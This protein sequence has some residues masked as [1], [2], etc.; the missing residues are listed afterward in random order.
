MIDVCWDSQTYNFGQASTPAFDFVR[1][2]P[3][4]PRRM[5]IVFR[6][7]IFGSGSIYFNAKPPTVP[8]PPGLSLISYFQLATGA[9]ASTPPIHYNHFG[10]I[11][12]Q[13]IFCASIPGDI[14]E[15][16]EM[17]ADFTGV[18]NSNDGLTGCNL[19][20]RG[21]ASIHQVGTPAVQLLQQNPQRTHVIIPTVNPNGASFL[22]SASGVTTNRFLAMPDSSS[23]VLDIS[24]V[25]PIVTN[26]WYWMPTVDGTAGQLAYE[27]FVVG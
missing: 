23:A 18:T 21:W 7:K 1:L 19:G 11:M 9:L 16:A 27:L 24:D 15:Y 4:N 20:F 13:E 14:I 22:A 17:S 26:P 5:W 25:G 12:Q 8:P 6:S 2:A 10:P 3:A